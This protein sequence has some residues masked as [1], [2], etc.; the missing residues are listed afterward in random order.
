[1]TQPVFVNLTGGIGCGKSTIAKMFEHCGAAVIDADAISR[2]LTAP[3][4]LALAPILRHFG[5]AYVNAQTGLL[6]ESMR[7]L[8]FSNPAAKQALE[9]ILHPLIRAEIALQSQKA[10]AKGAKIIMFDTPLLIE[11]RQWQNPH[12]KILVVDCF[13]ETQ[14][15]RVIARNQL[16][17]ETIQK[18]IASQASRTLR[19]KYADCVIFNELKSLDTLQSEVKDLWSHWL[20]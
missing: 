4:G 11:T 14:V 20:F 2:Q 5:T 16:S 15:N 7:N 10:I 6:R 3:A 17:K 9:S 19:L 12:S 8:V 18:I 13:A 1:M